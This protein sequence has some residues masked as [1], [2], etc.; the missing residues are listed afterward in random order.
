MKME[1]AYTFELSG[2]SLHA[3]LTVDL[4]GHELDLPNNGLGLTELNALLIGGGGRL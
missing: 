2:C 1:G 3:L 4:V